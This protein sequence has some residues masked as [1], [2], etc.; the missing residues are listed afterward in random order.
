MAQINTGK[1]GAPFVDMTPMVD[2]GF[3]LITFFMLTTTFSKPQAMEVNM[4]DKSEEQKE[5]EKMAV[6]ESNAMTILIGKNDDL[7]WYQ[8]LN[9]PELVKTDYSESGIRKVLLGKKKEIG[10][11]MFVLIKAMDQSKYVHMVDM[12]DEMAI[13]A[14]PTYAIVDI[15]DADLALINSKTGY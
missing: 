7:F 13:C 12:L 6:K 10:K 1:K 9:D 2:L 5:E 4:P 14:I 8:G 15:S 11:D 3:L